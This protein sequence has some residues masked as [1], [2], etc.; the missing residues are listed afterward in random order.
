MTRKVKLMIAVPLAMVAVVALFAVVGLVSRG[1]SSSGSSSAS[2]GA[3]VATST[4]RV[5]AESAPVPEPVMGAD[6]GTSGKST[7]GGDR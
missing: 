4:D 7:S 6:T 2:S 5:A 1:G 3:G